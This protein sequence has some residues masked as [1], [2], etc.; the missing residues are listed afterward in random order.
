[1]CTFRILLNVPMTKIHLTPTRNFFSF[2][3][4]ILKYIFFDKRICVH[5]FLSFSL[6]LILLPFF[7]SR[8][9]DTIR[10]HFVC[11]YSF[12]L[13]F[14][15]FCFSPSMV[16]CVVRWFTFYFWLHFYGEVFPNTNSIQYFISIHL[17]A[18]DFSIHRWVFCV[19]LLFFRFLYAIS[20]DFYISSS[21]IW[22]FNLPARISFK[23]RPVFFSVCFLAS[24]YLALLDDR[25]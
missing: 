5:F 2:V 6:S 21:F 4:I 19:F 8:R 15:W 20:F 12:N 1:M 16:C 18:S 9:F 10:F 13:N 14:L 17:N 23:F 24:Y 3:F 11:F 25:K 7:I 22:A